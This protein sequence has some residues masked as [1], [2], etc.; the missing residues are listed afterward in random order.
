MAE[1]G[2]KVAQSDKRALIDDL[3]LKGMPPKRIVLYLRNVHNFNDFTEKA[4]ADYRAVHFR[5]ENGLVAQIIKASQE[6][7][8]REP[9]A[10]SDRELLA[11]YF[12]FKA[13][14]DDLKLLYDRIKTVKEFAEKYPF[15]E[16]YD[17]RLVKLMAQAESIRTRVF[18]HQYE[19][20]RKAVL[21]NIGKKI[22][23]AAVN[24]FLAYIPSDRRKEAVQKFEAIV[25]PML[26]M[27]TN[28]A[29]EAISDVGDIVEGEARPEAPPDAP[30]QQ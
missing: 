30:P 13:T 24:V 2:D 12:S 17:E 25:K 20:I 5:S 16:S 15:D 6:L 18:R 10:T 19:H 9:P 14:N 29:A 22:C 7:A 4:I 3:L 21:L 11:G 23:M 28:E 1:P 26:E 27:T 8:D